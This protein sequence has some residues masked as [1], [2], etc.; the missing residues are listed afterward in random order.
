MQMRKIVAL[1]ATAIV[2]LGAGTAAAQ[3][4][5][6][7]IQTHHSA[8]SLPGQIFE[9]FIEDVETMSGGRIDIEGFWSSS[10]VK[11][12]ETFDAAATGILDGD[13]TGAAY[14]TGKDPGFQFLGDVMGG[15]DTPYQMIAWLEEGGGRELA[16]ELYHEHG[17][18]LVG[19]WLQGPES[20]SSTK[21]I[22][23]I[24][25]LEDWKF[26]SPPG[27]ETEIFTALGARPVVMDF[28]EVFTALETGIVDGADASALNT[29][30]SLGLYD[31][32]GY[33]TYPGWHSMPADH[34]AI[35]LDVWN[36]L[37]EDLQHIMYTAMDKAALHTAM[38]AEL[39]NKEAKRELE[40]QGVE[41]IDW[42]EEDRM[43]Y[44]DFA[45]DI[46]LEWAEKSP[47]AG[48]LVESHIEFMKR[49]DLLE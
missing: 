19:Y 41:V 5:T 8:E 11:S 10:V 36:S 12:V 2:A 14:L 28:G 48:K 27:M 22:R 38:R 39:L 40:A 17:M 16:N 31:V 35:N 34:L 24:E 33:A 21:P 7:R 43:A 30:K 44:R 18:H 25:D 4:F 49:I 23:T 6:L 32:T 29:N 37:P 46:W 20:L 13:M 1:T 45:R 42:S 47:A 3:E 9:Q 15:Y 26:R